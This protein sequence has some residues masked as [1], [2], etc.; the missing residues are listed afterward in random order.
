MGP[1]D[2]INGWSLRLA[3]SAL[4]GVLAVVFLQDVECKAAP[5]D[6]FF[7]TIAVSRELH[8]RGVEGDKEAVKEAIRHLEGMLAADS[9]NQLARVYL[10]SAFTLLSRD[11][12]P[13][14]EKL[15]KLIQG[16]RLMDEAVAA[17]PYDV[18]VRFVRAVNYYHLPSVF[19]KKKIARA[20]LLA[21]NNMID[22]SSQKLGP[23]EKQGVRYYAALALHDEGR[24]AEAIDALRAAHAIA[25]QSPLASTIAARLDHAV[26]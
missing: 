3:L 9:S 5:D 21:L 1:Y 10:G 24:K 17:A 4:S 18:R 11:L 8:D 14:S 2:F 26:R 22:T 19:G 16:G 25:P 20:E 15:S 12:P 7:G 13:G 23:V 6:G